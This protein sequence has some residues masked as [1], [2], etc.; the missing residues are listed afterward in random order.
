MRLVFVDFSTRLETVFDLQK[1]ARGGMVGSLFKVTDH[2]ASVGH[3][4]TVLSDIQHSG[5]TEAGTKWLHEAWG[6]Y[7]VLVANRGIGDGYPLIDA[8]KRVLWT[9]DLPHNGFVPDPKILHAFACVIFM[10]RYAEAIWRTFYRDIGRSVQIPNGVDLK[11]F[12]PLE[13]DLRYL[14]YF[15]HPIRGLKR[16][17][18]IADAIREKV[19]D[20][21]V[22]AFSNARA[23]YPGEPLQEDHGDQYALPEGFN[24]GSVELCEPLPSQQIAEEVGR[25]GLAIL[26]SGYPEIC[27]NAVLQALASG[28]PVITTGGLGSVPE[29]VKHRRN[30]MLTRYQPAD[31][32]VHTLEM[33]RHATEVLENESLH[34]SLIRRAASTRVLSWQEVGFKWERMLSRYS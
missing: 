30:G 31:Y 9:H 2:L 33:V 27:S 19:G 25:A 7:D 5:C 21:T 6:T 14:I 13:K 24:A 15:F 8:R 34:R 22:R 16:L 29:W 1:R 18:M 26:P 12:R 17:P 32:M 3:D 28:T 11:L 10:S 20:V 4:V 23:M